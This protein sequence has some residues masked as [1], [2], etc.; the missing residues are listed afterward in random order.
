MTVKTQ[1]GKVITK[2]GKVSC[3]CCGPGCCLYSALVLF[4]GQFLRAEDLPDNV[5]I[6]GISYARN[7][8]SYGNTTNGVALVG[9]KWVQYLQ[10]IQSIRDCLIQGNVFDQFADT[11]TLNWTDPEEGDFTAQVTRVSLCAWEGIDIAGN[12]VF[13]GWAEGSQRW[14]AQVILSD[15]EIFNG[16]KLNIRGDNQSSPSQG[17]GEYNPGGLFVS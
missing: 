3:E 6:S 2:G 11:Y 8:T 13:L 9:D 5:T 7:G 16:S 4:Q 10:G 1:S 12:P 14:F 15:G 17:T